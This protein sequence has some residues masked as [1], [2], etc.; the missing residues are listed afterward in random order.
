MD[1][2]RRFSASERLHSVG[3][4]FSG[5]KYVFKNE[6]NMWVHVGLFVVAMFLC[7][8]LSISVTQTISIF[9]GF[10]I[11]VAFECINSAIEYLANHLH[12]EVHMNIKKVKDVAAGAVLFSSVGLFLFCAVI[13]IPKIVTFLAI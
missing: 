11:V 1:T 9:F 8:I 6:H 12:P 4:A 5:I 3:F 13:F 2:K 10:S 7:W